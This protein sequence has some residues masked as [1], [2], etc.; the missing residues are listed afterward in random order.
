MSIASV[1]GMSV[2]ITA[3]VVAAVGVVIYKYRK[4]GAPLMHEMQETNV[5]ES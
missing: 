5:Y 2:G 4:R 1:I 3:V